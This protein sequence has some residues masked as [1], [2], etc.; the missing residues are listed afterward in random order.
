MKTNIIFLCAAAFC[1]AA[2]RRAPA[3][4]PSAT[5]TAAVAD[6]VD[7]ETGLA[8]DPNFIIVKAQCTGC[9]SPKLRAT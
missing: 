5:L 6:S 7:K 2:I 1:L 9:H 4:F 3:D 8:L